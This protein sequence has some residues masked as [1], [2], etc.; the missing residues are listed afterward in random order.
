MAYDKS[1]LELL[2]GGGASFSLWGY[3]TSADT[4]AQVAASGYFD[5]ASAMLKAGD[6][7]LI[8][9]GDGRG[10]TAVTANASGT[11]GVSALLALGSSS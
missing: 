4:K 2:A 9:A 1:K 10:I 8:S 7:L 5:D 11:V 6:W 3:A